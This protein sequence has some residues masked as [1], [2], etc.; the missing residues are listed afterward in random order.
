M[1]V[2][3]PSH[4]FYVLFVQPAIRRDP[5]TCCKPAFPQHPKVS[6][7]SHCAATEFDSQQT[8]F[9]VDNLMRDE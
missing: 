2:W 7:S 4:T 3:W 8:R 1:F 5:A 6:A 9:T